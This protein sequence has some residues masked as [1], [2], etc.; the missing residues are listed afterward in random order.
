MLGGGGEVR[1]G[2]TV[3]TGEVQCTVGMY[4]VQWGGTMY[5]GDV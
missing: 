3:Y 1:W 5:G 2:G 4:S